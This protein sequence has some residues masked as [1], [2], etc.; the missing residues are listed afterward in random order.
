MKKFKN[1]NFVRDFSEKTGID[2]LRY[3]QKSHE[4]VSDNLKITQFLKSEKSYVLNSYKSFD[5]YL[6]EFVIDGQQP[7]SIVNEEKFRA[8]ITSLSFQLKIPSRDCYSMEFH[9]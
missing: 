2:S 6:I 4:S 3:H 1:V 7:F 8:L 9:L 5:D